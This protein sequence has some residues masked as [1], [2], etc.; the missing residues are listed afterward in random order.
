MREADGRPR[1][2]EREDVM[3]RQTLHYR[4]LATGLAKAAAAT[5]L[6]LT[7]SVLPAAAELRREQDIRYAA[8][9]SERAVALAQQ[10]PESAE[11]EAEAEAARARRAARR[12]ADLE[13]FKTAMGR[14]GEVLGGG[15]TPAAPPVTYPRPAPPQRPTTPAAPVGQRSTGPTRWECGVQTQCVGGAR[16]E[17]APGGTAQLRLVDSQGTVRAYMNIYWTSLGPANGIKS[18]LLTVTVGIG[19]TSCQLT[20]DVGFYVNGRISTFLGGVGTGPEVG[21]MEYRKVTRE[22][23]IPEGATI[24]VSPGAA[25]CGSPR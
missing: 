14:L 21:P 22:F 18:R 20:S 7:C 1:Q 13:K 9:Q 3:N 12:Q 23:Y 2:H 16:A 19:S 15:R 4:F 24:T 5:G 8:I 6:L 11:D 25:S 10:R 17:L